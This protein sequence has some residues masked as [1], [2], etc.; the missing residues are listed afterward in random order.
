MRVVVANLTGGGLSGGYRK[1]LQ[2]LMPLLAAD[3]RVEQLHVFLPAGS[4]ASFDPALDVRPYAA[5]DAGGRAVHEAMRA[6][7]PDIVFVPTARFIDIGRPVVTMVRN[8]EPLMVPFGGNSWR[9]ALRNLA[10]AGQAKRASRRATRVIAVSQFVREFLVRQWS[11]PADRVGVVYHGVD[12]PG[13]DAA[14]PRSGGAVTRR[15]LFTAGS[16]RPARGLEDAIDALPRLPADVH[17]TIGGR[18]DAGAEHYAARLHERAQRLGVHSRITFAGHLDAPQVYAA[19]R[20]CDVFVMTSR[21]EACPNTALEAMSAG[22]PIVSV[23]HEPMPEFF[24]TAALYYRAGSGPALADRI[25]DI[26]SGRVDRSELAARARK[27]ASQFDWATTADL[28]I[29]QLELA[30]S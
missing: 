26:L 20:D 11:L 9:E 2:R 27:R 15:T 3:R 14:P 22:A 18:V 10:R 12:R 23:G 16:I 13:A 21:A 5:G 24:G 8:M 25:L 1:Y 29:R 28:T 4:V 19:M 30:L 7:S 6:L 17:L